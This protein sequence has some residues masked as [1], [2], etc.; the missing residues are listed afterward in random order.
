DLIAFLFALTDESNLPEFPEKVP[1]GLPVVPHLKNPA[2]E[3]VAKANTG[4]PKEQI[5]NR[6]PQTVRVKA[7]ESIQ[8]A[9]DKAIPGDI[10]EVEPGIYKEEL[11][12]DT[13]NITLRGISTISPQ[14]NALTR[15]VLEG[16]KKLSDA[17]LSTGNNFV[18]ENFDVKHYIAN[19]V[20]AQHANN[21]T[22]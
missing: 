9:L 19:G 6:A 2:R 5:A 11:K 3:L 8:A 14:A 21:V 12:T 22:L 16:E 20:M 15:P 1:S 10:I 7:G 4:M 18:M 13:D 17:V